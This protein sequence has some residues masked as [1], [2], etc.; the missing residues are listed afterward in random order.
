MEARFWRRIQ[1]RGTLDG[2]VPDSTPRRSPGHSLCTVAFWVE[3]VD[4]CASTQ[5]SSPGLSSTL[6]PHATFQ[7]AEQAVWQQLCS[8]LPPLL[9]SLRMSVRTEGGFS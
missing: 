7:G 9:E 8:P 4:G 1:T 6:G 3:L 2:I 5:L